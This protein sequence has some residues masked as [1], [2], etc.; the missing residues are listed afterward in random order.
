MRRRCGCGRRRPS[1]FCFDLY[2]SV[3]FEAVVDAIEGFTAWVRSRE[4]R[5][6]A[7]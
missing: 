1:R 2:H 6:V 7:R 5:A 4:R 3:R